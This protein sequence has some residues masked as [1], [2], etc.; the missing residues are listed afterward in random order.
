MATSVGNTEHASRLWVC[1]AHYV[2]DLSTT[3]SPVITNIPGA[4]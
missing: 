4:L 2:V 3:M 1:P